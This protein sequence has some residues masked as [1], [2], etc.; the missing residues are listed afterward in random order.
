[1]GN[2]TFSPTLTLANG[3]ISSNSILQL[4]GASYTEILS[5]GTQSAM[6]SSTKSSLIFTEGLYM[7]STTSS[8]GNSTT[9]PSGPYVTVEGRL[10]LRKG[11]PLLYP[12]GTTGAYVRNIYIK[13]TT[14]NPSAS[15][16]Y[17]GD[18]M[19]TY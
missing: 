1:V 2:Q 18:I 3:K 9:P 7:G 10:R 8:V 16:G 19:M 15:T 5:G 4:S 11:A 14:A 6:F 17:V 13:Q 12:G